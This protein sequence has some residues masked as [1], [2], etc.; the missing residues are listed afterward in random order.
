MTTADR[1]IRTQAQEEW[2]IRVRET[3]PDLR[4]ALRWALDGA[5][6]NPLHEPGRWT[7]H[8]SLAR[9]VAP[10]QRAAV[11]AV[12]GDVAG[13]WLVSARSYDS[14]TRTV[15]DLPAAP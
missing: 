15:R 5:D 14:L 2:L 13:G 7:P 6:R 4:A 3:L 11:Q 9:K 8:L 12:A 1:Q 10:E